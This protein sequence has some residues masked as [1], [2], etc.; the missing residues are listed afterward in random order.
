MLRLV[1]YVNDHLYTVLVE[2]LE[3]EKKLQDL[4]VEPESVIQERNQLKDFYKNLENVKN[5][6]NEIQEQLGKPF[7]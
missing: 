7:T 3:R 1:N 2:E 4:L 5:E 6:I